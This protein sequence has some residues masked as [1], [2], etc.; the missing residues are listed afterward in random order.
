MVGSRTRGD[1]TN[2]SDIDLAI[3]SDD[4]KGLNALERRALLKDFV[5]PG[6]ST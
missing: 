5:G 6:W 1:Y 2:K 4:V 3:I